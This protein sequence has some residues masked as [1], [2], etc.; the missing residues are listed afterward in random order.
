MGF[1]KSILVIAA[2]LCFQ[3]GAKDSNLPVFDLTT[4]DSLCGGGI[5]FRNSKACKDYINLLKD[6]LKS[7]NVIYGNNEPAQAPVQEASL[8]TK[9][10]SSR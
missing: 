6:M 1:K 7:T 10:T 8:Q 4:Y 9:D 5:R 2:C 3:A